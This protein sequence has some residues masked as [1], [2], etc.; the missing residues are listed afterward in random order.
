MYDIIINPGTAKYDNVNKKDIGLNLDKW[1]FE[2]LTDL[3]ATPV[4]PTNVNN[5]TVLFLKKGTYKFSKFKDVKFDKSLFNLEKH[6]VKVLEQYSIS[7]ITDWINL[8]K[9]CDTKVDLRLFN[10]NLYFSNKKGIKNN[11]SLRQ[12]LKKKSFEFG[13]NPLDPCC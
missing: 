10:E 8:G 3:G 12:W 4:C 13:L 5:C 9:C 7:T 11:M 2:L 6:I 1:L